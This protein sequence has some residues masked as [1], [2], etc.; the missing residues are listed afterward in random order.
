MSD[1][2]VPADGTTGQTTVTRW[3]RYGHDRLYVKDAAGTDLGYWDLQTGTAHPTHPGWHGVVTEAARSWCA[4]S[5]PPA[6]PT[7]PTLP[8]PAVAPERPWV[9]L[10][11]NRPG[12]AVREVAAAKYAAAPVRSTLGRLFGLPTEETSWRRGAE[13]EEKVA[14][15]L[16]KLTRRDPRWR[17]LHSVGVGSR[18]SDIDHV[19]IGPAGVFTLNAKNHRGKRI[20]VGGNTVRVDT[21]RT[22]YVRNARHEAARASSLLSAALGWSVPVHGVVVPVGAIEVT[23]QSQPLEVTVVPRRQLAGW[24]GRLGPLLTQEQV[25]AVYEVARRST[26]WR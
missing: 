6:A 19:V 21:H 9:D 8:T 10:A 1:L 18:G 4:T 11:T 2:A 23:V 3:R 22:H 15:Q 24:L 17:A 5:G 13:G 20:W 26:T 16:A 12:E 25:E 14:A 7:P